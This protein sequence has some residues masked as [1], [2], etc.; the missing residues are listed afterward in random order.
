[1]R[2]SYAQNISPD[3]R[4]HPKTLKEAVNRLAENMALK[5][6][7]TVANMTEK[8]M[9]ALYPRLEKYIRVHFGLI[10]GNEDL[11]RSCIHEL[12]D[13][14]S[15]RAGCHRGDDPGALENIAGYPSVENRKVR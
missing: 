14:E 11:I 7:V 1:M 6:R 13:Q 15:K 4:N 2:Q 3:I 12:N 5:D 8:E 10:S 9:E